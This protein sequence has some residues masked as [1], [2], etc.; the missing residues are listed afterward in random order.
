MKAWEKQKTCEWGVDGLQFPFNWDM[1]AGI[2]WYKLAM[3][4]PCTAD[5]IRYWPSKRGKYVQWFCQT[6]YDTYTY[7]FI[8]I[9][10]NLIYIMIYICI[11]IYNMYT[12]NKYRLHLHYISFRRYIRYTTEVTNLRGHDILVFFGWPRWLAATMRPDADRGDFTS[13]HHDLAT[14]F[15]RDRQFMHE[16]IIIHESHDGVTSF[17]FEL[18]FDF[19]EQ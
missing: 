19:T 16:F 13:R 9:Y 2:N 1:F 14:I 7:I 11:Y 12:Y 18:G 5:N 17:F 3:Y 10:D 4:S 15:T 6:Q 8:Y